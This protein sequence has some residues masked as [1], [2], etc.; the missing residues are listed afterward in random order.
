MAVGFQPALI[1]LINVHHI[2]IAGYAIESIGSVLVGVAA[3]LLTLELDLQGLPAHDSSI[4]PFGH[5]YLRP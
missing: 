5:P 4:P 2:Q 3:E 1:T